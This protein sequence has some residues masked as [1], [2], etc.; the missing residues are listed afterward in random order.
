MA[1]KREKLIIFR[2]VIEKKK[3]AKKNVI[4][5]DGVNRIP[6]VA[7]RG[8]WS[9]QRNFGVARTW[10][11]LGAVER[12]CTAQRDVGLVSLKERLW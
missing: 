5:I 8:A 1:A 9:A 10:I 12:E 6:T 4:T 7:W 3:V 2:C 11:P